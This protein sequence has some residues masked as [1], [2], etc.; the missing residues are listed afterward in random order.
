MMI[1]MMVAGHCNVENKFR[2]GQSLLLDYAYCWVWTVL[3][4]N[5]EESGR[6]KKMICV[7]KRRRK[8]K[9]WNLL[10]LRLV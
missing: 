3:L 5:T 2:E 1:V 10:Q 7:T 9:M 6:K 4:N 8:S